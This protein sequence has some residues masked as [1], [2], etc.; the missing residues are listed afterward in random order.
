MQTKETDFKSV[1]GN[2]DMSKEITLT[3]GKVAFV[4]DEDYPK[5]FG[6]KWR[7]SSRGYAVRW[8][9]WGSGKRRMVLM[10]RETNKTP[11]GF[12]TDHI[13]HNKLDNRK[14]NLRT[15][16]HAENKQNSVSK[17]GTSQY[18]GVYWHKLR[19]IWMARIT[20]FKKIH[21]LG[22]YDDEEMAAMAY[23]LI[24]RQVFK[25]FAKLNFT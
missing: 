18:K 15:C 13:N 9:S 19:K 21:Y 20:I 3:Q 24:A 14:I 22:C 4:D 1:A 12:G 6:Y 8:G 17:V 10:H 2:S 7:F 25:K 16:N 5:L 11:N 23:D